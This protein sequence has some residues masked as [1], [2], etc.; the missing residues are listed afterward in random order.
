MIRKSALI[1]SFILIPFFFLSAETVLLYTI[2]EADIVDTDQ[3]ADLIDSAVMNEFFDAGH[4]VFN[5]AVSGSVPDIGLEHYKEAHSMQLAKA[6]GAA[7]LMEVNL[8]YSEMKG[9]NL[10]GYAEFRLIKVLSG[11]IVK[12]G[13]VNIDTKWIDKGDLEDDLTAMGLSMASYVLTFL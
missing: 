3:F 7:F 10:P 6:G 11:D 12:E 9:I 5:A 4:I 2:S 8:V 13:S 1:L